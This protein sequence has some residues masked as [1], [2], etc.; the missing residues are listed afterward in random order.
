MPRP[1]T[2]FLAICSGLW[3]V[4][5]MLAGSPY[6]PFPTGPRQPPSV[7][8]TSS[9]PLEITVVHPP[10]DGDAAGAGDRLLLRADSGYQI[11]SRDSTF[12]FGSTGRG[13]ARL[14]INGREVAVYPTGGWLAWLPLPNDSLARFEIAAV[15]GTEVAEMEF[16]VPLAA[17]P[18]VPPEGAWIDSTSL[19]PTGD[20]WL[21]QGEGLALSLRAT[22]GA[23]VQAVLGDGRR[24]PFVTDPRPDPLSW[25]AR[26]FDSQV[27]NRDSVPASRD[28][29]V[30]WWVSRLG[31]GPGHLLQ[32]DSVPEPEDTSWVWVEAVV[33]PDT[34]RIRWPLRIGVVDPN[35]SLVVVVDDDPSG[36]G[37]TDATLP[38]RPVPYGTYHWFFP[39]GTV[40]AVSGRS[41]DQ[42][43]LQ[44]SRTSVAWVDAAE[45]AG[46][47]LGTPPP[48]GRVRSLRLSP[49]DSS[50][51][52]RIPLP[53][54]LPFSI[55]ENRAEL[56]VR[57]Y[58]VA[59]DTDWIQYGGTDPLVRLV[60]FSQDSE[61]ETVVTLSLAR[62]VWGYRTR[63]DGN[64][65]LVEVR[66]PPLID[67]QRPLRGRTIA[68]DAG[69]PPGGAKG[70]TGHWE[71]DVVLGV[72]LKTAELLERYGA[73]VVL[74]RD[75]D[76]PTGLYERTLTAEQSGA[77]LLVSIHANALP[78][79]VNPLVNNGTSVYYFH[80]R[81]ADLAR[82]LNRALVRQFG[83]PD[84]GFGRGD[85]ALARP[86]WMPS[87]LAEGLFM[88]IP[89]QEAVLVSDE[90][91]WRYARGII[92]G[93]AAFLRERALRDR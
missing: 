16:V 11:Q 35:M 90:G 31:P 77:E 37:T 24:V 47:P 68:L 52:L 3:G 54:R 69:H 89:E 22:P 61:D 10:N 1:V 62:E 88:M 75:S 50:T 20:V 58:G 80:P 72:A 25:G 30:T 38:G 23:D 32:P 12:L 6:E 81:S 26:A 71:P 64:D 53:A 70:P 93:V 4:A 79:G 9:G 29:F 28:R 43:R 87:A 55:E 13:D 7:A 46:L 45:V 84:L 14:L 34:A 85:L 18:A 8:A 59:A 78:D 39:N 5:C 66:R 76:D 67:A 65:L 33:V 92:E 15:A 40:A 17:R 21:R 56:R 27:S 49:A 57:L 44:L 73:R 36:S 51:T 2:A 83:F 63:W 48:R 60:A 42:I 86:T 41:N 82:E 91:Q 74:T 19:S